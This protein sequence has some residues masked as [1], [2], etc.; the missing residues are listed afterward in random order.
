[1]ATAEIRDVTKVEIKRRLKLRNIDIVLVYILF[2]GFYFLKDADKILIPYVFYMTMMIG[3]YVHTVSKQHITGRKRFLLD[4]L[5]Y[6]MNDIWSPLLIW[7]VGFWFILFFLFKALGSSIV[8]P[9]MDVIIFQ[10]GLV[11]P[12]ETFIFAVFLPEITGK[13]LGIPGWVWG[14]GIFFGLFHFWAY[15]AQISVTI[16]WS[17]MVAG[18][19]GICF[20][21]LYKLGDRNKRIGGIMATMS[22]HFVLNFWIISTGTII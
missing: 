1:M 8:Y 21:G 14:A 19:M 18:L 12:S 22:V 9:E 11:I 5:D 2:A 13:I 3:V 20:Y 16:I 15:G 7:G 10:F 4:L 6:D 17:I